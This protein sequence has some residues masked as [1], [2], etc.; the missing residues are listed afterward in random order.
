MARVKMPIDYIE[1]ISSK[2]ETKELGQLLREQYLKWSRSLRLKDFLRFMKTIQDNKDSIGVA[3]LF[4]KFRAYSFEEY[5]Y[6]LIVAKVLLPKNLRAYWCEKC[7]IWR[8]R[9]QAYGTEI[10]IAIGK[11][12]GEFVD[13]VVVVE[14]KVELDASRLKTALASFVIIKNWNPKAKCFLVYL[15][16]KVDQ[17]LLELTK[18]WID[19]IY[20]FSQGTNQVE[21][22]LGFIK[23]ALHTSQT[24][25][26]SSFN[27]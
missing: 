23:E 12:R 16:K 7:L 9:K 8:N 11:K 15:E 19:G 24:E 6:R 22:F 17:S 26:R 5:V 21:A 13:P 1:K 10:D 20:N 4:G 27:N 14:V 25:L 3:Q 18:S 2:E